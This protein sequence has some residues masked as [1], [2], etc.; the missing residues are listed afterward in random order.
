[1]SYVFI[2]IGIPLKGR[3]KLVI[4]LPSQE[5]KPEPETGKRPLTPLLETRDIDLPIQ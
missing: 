1:M 4:P 3:K 5:S 2:H